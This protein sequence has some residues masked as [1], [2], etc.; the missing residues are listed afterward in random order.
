MKVCHINLAKTFRGGERQTLILM[1]ELAKQGVDQCLVVRRDGGAWADS[2]AFSQHEIRKTPGN[3]WPKLKIFEDIDLIHAH[4][5][6]ALRLAFAAHKRFAIPYVVTRRIVQKPSGNTL[7]KRSYAAAAAVVAV[8]SVIQPVIQP[9][10]RVAVQRIPDA[11]ANL[12]VDP[13][14]ARA[15]RSRYPGKFIIGHVG[16]L[17]NVDKGQLHLLNIAEALNELAPDV[18]LLFLGAGSDSQWF[19][20]LSEQ[21]SNVEFLGFQRDVGDFIAAFDL[22]V[23]PSLREGLG[24]TLLDVMQAN[25]PIIASEVG[26]I[27][28][29]IQHEHN[30]LLF[31]KGDEQKLLQLILQLYHSPDLRTQLALKAAAGLEQFSPHQIAQQYSVLYRKVLHNQSASSLSE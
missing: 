28:D 4:D 7:N 16:A 15:I 11:Y 14:R 3:L 20:A 31:A 22:F 25:V 6:K 23:F 10:A 24:S 26:G 5:A 30:G 9:M 27:V 19:A 17:E 8:S 29:I 18:Q 12:S 2:G 21:L 1:N 13:E